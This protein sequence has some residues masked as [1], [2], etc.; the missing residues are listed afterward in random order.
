MVQ[1]TGSLAIKTVTGRYGDF[2]VATLDCELGKFAIR[3][4]MLDEYNE[5]TYQGTFGVKRIFSGSY[6]TEH[7]V[8]IET[9]AELSGIWLNDYQ[10][11]KVPEE[12]LESDPLAEERQAQAI[13]RS[14]RQTPAQPVDDVSALFGELWPLGAQIG[15][16]V[17][18]TPEVGREVMGRQLTYLKRLID[19]ERVWRFEP[20]AQHWTRIRLD[21]EV[22]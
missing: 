14:E 13:Q 7:R 6:Q 21:E 12:S 2:N 9:R 11:G 4:A 10:E 15:D 5:G 19:G 16:V 20:K 1:I 17:K 22:N 3:D 18:L 8:V